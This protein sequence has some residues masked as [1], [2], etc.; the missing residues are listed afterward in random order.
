ME[1]EME[2]LD[3][4]LL[5]MLAKELKGKQWILLT[6]IR[7]RIERDVF[8]NIKTIEERRQLLANID[9]MWS[10]VIENEKRKIGVD[11]KE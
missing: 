10:N 8:T 11:D 9:Y 5:A 4:E 2:K 6:E 1:M 3:D 7:D